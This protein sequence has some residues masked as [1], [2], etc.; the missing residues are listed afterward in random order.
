MTSETDLDALADWLDDEQ[1]AE[2]CLDIH[3]LHGYLT[4]L[5]ICGEALSDEWLS[6]TLGQ[7]LTELPEEE[8]QQYAD[9]CVILYREIFD[10]LYS[11]DQVALSFEPST[12]WE[13][14]DM[15]AWAIGFMEVVFALPDRWTHGSE[16]DLATLLLPIEAASGLFAEEADYLPLYRNTALLS[17]MF[18]D[19]P[20]VLTDLYLLLNSPK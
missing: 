16:E 2:D 13:D 5:A 12:D 19:I 10:E 15:Q 17:Q 4:A 20:D 18:D 8:A 7:P 11:D 3:G 6:E 9:T 1:R 14:S